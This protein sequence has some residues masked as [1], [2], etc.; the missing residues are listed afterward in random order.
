M[1]EVTDR[2]CRF[3]HRLLGPDIVLYTEMIHAS[4]VVNGNSEKLLEYD[5]SEHPV[6]LQLGGNSPKSLALATK[7]ASKYYYDEVNLN[8]GC[9]S[10]K[11]LSGNFG[12]ALMKTPHLVADCIKA[13]KDASE[14]E[15]SIKHRI[16]FD[17]E[18]DYA[19]VRDFVGVLH[20][21]GCSLFFVHARSA[22]SYLSPKKNRN[23]PPIEMDK[24]RAL[25]RDFPDCYFVAN[26]EI[27][28]LA[29]CF[30]IL[31]KNQNLKLPGLDG[32][33]LGRAV[34]KLPTLLMDLQRTF[35]S[36]KKILSYTD[37]L[38]ILENYYQS[39]RAC[40]IDGKKIVRGWINLFNR[41]KGA[42]KW[43]RFITQGLGPVEA[44]ERAFDS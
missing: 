8:C 10:S 24:V 42:K 28:S 9:P 31:E 32:V 15:V 1:M 12:V 33:M 37:I 16:G 27:D 43:R 34:W 21:A 23:I 11:V 22:I 30:S 7:I 6:G 35:Y 41:K 38:V 39:Q 14:I 13:M 3:F 25:K 44:Y 26:G 17:D 36:E 4:A 29:K 2:H 18:K 5:K 40:G 20:E 19:F